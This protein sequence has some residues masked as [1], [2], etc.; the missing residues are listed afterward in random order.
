MTFF[1]LFPTPRND[2]Y[3]DV[4]LVVDSKEISAHKIL[5]AAVSPYFRA[6]FSNFAE[7]RQDKINIGGVDYEA[8]QLLIEFLYTACIE[9][10]T[11]NVQV[12]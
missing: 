5:L 3:C 1:H 10:T 6:M 7:A 12:I 8:L 11:Y 9:I 2:I 4:R